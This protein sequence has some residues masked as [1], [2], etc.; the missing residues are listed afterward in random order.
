MGIAP[1]WGP[2]AGHFVRGSDGHSRGIGS[3]GSGDASAAG[4]N[5]R[6]ISL[7]VGGG[8]CDERNG[9]EGGRGRI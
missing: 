3:Y 7:G 5:V 9:K 1:H 2:V 8:G 6:G 4:G